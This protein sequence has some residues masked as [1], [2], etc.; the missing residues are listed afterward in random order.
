MEHY[1]HIAGYKGRRET[2][3]AWKPFSGDFKIGGNPV[4]RL[5]GA[6]KDAGGDV[7]SFAWKGLKQYGS[8]A[9]NFWTLGAANKFT[10]VSKWSGTKRA[11][12]WGTATGISAAAVAT[13]FAGSALLTP[14]ATVS[15]SEELSMAGLEALEAGSGPAIATGVEAGASAGTGSSIL[16]GIKSVSSSLASGIFSAVLSSGQKAVNSVIDR[17]VSSVFGGGPGAPGTPGGSGSGEGGGILSSSMLPIILIG[18]T[19]L[20]FFILTRKRKGKV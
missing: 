9:L 17:E 11:G 4:E 6:L 12:K 2:F 5:G 1:H 19:I 14:A 3:R 16:S 10:S 20:G 8:F 7:G 13:V 15:T 18:I